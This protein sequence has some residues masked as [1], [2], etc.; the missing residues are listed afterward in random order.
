MEYIEGFIGVNTLLKF[1]ITQDYLKIAVSR[2]NNTNTGSWENIKDPKDQRKVLIKYDTIPATTKRKYNMPEDF[3][4]LQHGLYMMEVRKRAV[5]NEKKLKKLDEKG[6]MEKSPMFK[7]IND[8]LE[9]DWKKHYKHYESKLN[10]STCKIERIEELAIKY[11]KMEALYTN[12]IELSG[13][14]FRTIHGSIKRLYNFM[15]VYKMYHLIPESIPDYIHFSRRIAKYK[16]V[17]QEGVLADEFV[18]DSK[19]LKSKKL[20]DEFHKSMLMYYASNPKHYSA[21]QLAEFINFHAEKESKM[22]IS[23][24]WVKNMLNNPNDNSFRTMIDSARMGA[25]YTNDTIL[26]YLSRTDSMYPN[27]TWFIDG[28]PMQIYS[29]DKHGR[30]QR[31]YIF[32]VLDACTRRIVGFDINTTGEDRFMV[33]NAIKMAIRYTGYIPYEIVSDNFSANKTEEIKN[34][35]AELLKFGTKW[36]FAK[37]G[38]AQDKSQVERF[39]GTFQTVEQSILEEYIGE[40]ITTRRDNGRICSEFLKE[41]FKKKGLYPSE[42]MKD[43]VVGLLCIYNAKRMGGRPSPNEKYNSLS[44][45]QAIPLDKI[46]I[47]KLF[48]YKTE[49]TVKRGQVT[50]RRNNVVYEYDI[51]DKK[52]TIELQGQKVIVRY[53]E[54]YHGSVFIYDY[55]T[56]K[57]IKEIKLKVKGFVSNAEVPEGMEDVNIKFAS[58]KKSHLTYM[59][60]ERKR[61]IDTGLALVGKTQET[62]DAVSAL[63]LNKHHLNAKESIELLGLY[64]ED[65][66]RPINHLGDYNQVAKTG[67]PINNTEKKVSETTKNFTGDKNKKTLKAL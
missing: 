66:N 19:F 5:R 15:Q 65:L 57:L 9:K 33:M 48:W 41:L 39:N 11:S 55:R 16:K 46:N 54:D 38:N 25:K 18:K 4:D 60:E 22:H 49:A 58:H 43:F 29:K 40:G 51:W 63:D 67:V 20:T 56:D 31:L 37:V 35:Q 27:N 12:Y 61:I 3:E 10:Y 42:T 14:K 32:V 28:T 44:I 59:E 7:R 1:G 62:F 17:L 8:A 53:K 2:F 13:G 23:E 52:L 45:D 64:Q 36:R 24:S 21:R 34:L 6:Q 30:M 50:L 26:P 47:P